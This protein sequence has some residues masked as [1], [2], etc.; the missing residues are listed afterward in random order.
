MSSTAPRRALTAAAFGFTV[1]FVTS[2]SAGQDRAAPRQAPA[3]NAAQKPV[4]ASAT[5][6]AT[7]P[8]DDPVLAEVDGS[9]NL[10]LRITGA[11]RS[12]G[13]KW[14]TLRGTITNAGRSH[15]YG[16]NK[17]RGDFRNL[18]KSPQSVAGATI[19]DEASA[20]RYYVLRDT[21]GLCLCTTHIQRVEAGKSLPFTAQFPAPPADS[22]ELGFQLPGFPVATFTMGG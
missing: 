8:A 10:T 14:L 4:A 20:K 1:L 13:G 15:F 3:A 7:T 22:A 11:Q 17:W 2:C 9:D 6:T 19:V 21:T 12:Q 18:A 16:T 5:S